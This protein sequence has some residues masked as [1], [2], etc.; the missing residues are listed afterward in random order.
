MNQV[1]SAYLDKFVVVFIDDILVYLRDRDDH[2][3]HL[4]S[5]LQ[6]LR[7]NKLYAKLSKCDFWLEKVSFLGHFVSKEGISVDPAKVV[8]VRS[9]PSPKNVTEVRSFLGLAGYYR[10]FVKDFSRIARPMTSLMKKEKKFEWTDECEQPFITLK[11][12]L[13]T[14]PVLTLPDPKLD[15]TDRKVTVYASRQ[16]KVHEVHYPTHDLELAA[17]VFALKIWRHYLYGVKCK[18]YTDHQSLK[19]LYT[20]PDLNMRQRRWLELMTDYDLEFIY[21]EG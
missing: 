15:Y 2:E 21:Y 5:V 20:Q 1:F 17:I 14:A 8:A 3:K 4:R 6:T 9:W 7:E 11:E 16:L 13:T 12:R 10:R 18:I 19:Y